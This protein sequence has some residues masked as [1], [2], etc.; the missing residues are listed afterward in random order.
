MDRPIRLAKLL[1]S[2]GALLTVVPI[3]FMVV[4]VIA[5]QPDPWTALMSLGWSV[6]VAIALLPLGM[7]FLFGGL[8]WIVALKRRQKQELESDDEPTAETATE[9]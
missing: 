6:I 5:L 4:S 8:G 7:A 2:V 1:V 3:G 9:K